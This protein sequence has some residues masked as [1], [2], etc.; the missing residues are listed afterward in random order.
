MKIIV[1]GGGFSGLHAIKALSRINKKHEIVLFDKNNYTAMLPSL[2]DLVIGKLDK[3]FLIGNISKLLPKNI[4]FKNEKI[5]N[6]DFYKKSIVSEKSKYIYDYIIIAGGSVANFFNFKKNIDKIYRLDSI[7]EAIKIKDALNDSI[8][9]N[10][11]VNIVISGAGYT[12]IELAVNMRYFLTTKNKN[13]S[14]YLIQKDNDILQFLSTNEKEYIKSYLD[15]ENIKI[16]LNSLITDF[17]GRNVII[18]K[19]GKIENSLLV[20]TAGTK[21]SIENINGNFE[22]IN[23]GRLIVNEF[24]QIP[25]HLDVFAAGDSAAIKIEKGYLRKD[26]FNSVST[27]KCAGKNIIRKINNK[28]L[29]RFKS[30]DLAWII[31]LNKI[32]VGRFFGK[33]SFKGKIG[34]RLHYFLCGYRNYNFKNFIEYIKLTLKLK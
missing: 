23:D 24:L 2:P 30:F 32:S 4:V 9:K 6:I 1:I 16:L 10:Q 31:P 12:G 20:W 21:F 11:N 19:S 22:R 25:E 28:K 26:V 29:K 5:I 33:I 13:Y 14:I 34:L 15:K 7:S 27:G 8:N 18:N 17:D 3:K